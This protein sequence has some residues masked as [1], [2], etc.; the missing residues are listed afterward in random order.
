MLK[1]KISSVRASLGELLSKPLDEDSLGIIR[2]CR[3]NLGGME[4]V[5]G[6]LETKLLVPQ[7]RREVM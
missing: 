6:V 3:D 7:D 1:E 4:E 2:A 5:A